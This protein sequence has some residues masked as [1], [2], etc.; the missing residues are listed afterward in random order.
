MCQLVSKAGS[1]R[2]ARVVAEGGGLIRIGAYC[3]VL[4]N[5]VIR[6]TVKHETIIGDHCLIGPN[7]HVVEATIENEVFVATGASIFHGARLGTGSEVRVNAVVH[8]RT[9]LPPNETVPIGWIAVGTPAQLFS[10]DRHGEI[11]QV[12]QP[13]NFPDFVYGVDRHMP[14]LM[15]TVTRNLS[16]MLAEAF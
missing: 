10:P 8:L 5:A 13:L 4:E 14:H 15:Q 6:A 7:S 2:G 1:C 11:W 9:V 12:Q 3:I 16:A